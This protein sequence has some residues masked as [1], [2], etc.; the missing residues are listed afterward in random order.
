MLTGG[1]WAQCWA[2]RLTDRWAPASGGRGREEREARGVR[3]P[4]E[5]E[6]GG[7]RPDE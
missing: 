3:G 4:A 7:P 1:L 6:G 2:V 5:K